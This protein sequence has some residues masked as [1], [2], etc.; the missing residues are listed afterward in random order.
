M[1]G[2]PDMHSLQGEGN[3]K[4]QE[5]SEGSDTERNNANGSSSSGK[6]KRADKKLK[7]S[8]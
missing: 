4:Y 8:V 7:T 3:A 2:V 6:D 5:D 1:L